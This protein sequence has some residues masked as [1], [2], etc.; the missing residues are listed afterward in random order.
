[1]TSN[2]AFTVDD[3]LS[4]HS[5]LSDKYLQDARQIALS[6]QCLCWSAQELVNQLVSVRGKLTLNRW[7]GHKWPFQ[8]INGRFL[9]PL[10]EHEA[11]QALIS[12]QL[13]SSL[14]AE[15]LAIQ[16]GSR[17]MR[18]L[19]WCRSHGYHVT[20]KS[21]FKFR[22]EWH[23]DYQFDSRLSVSSRLF[24]LGLSAQLVDQL[25]AV[26]AHQNPELR[27]LLELAEGKREYFSSTIELDGVPF[28]VKQ[29]SRGQLFSPD[30][31][32]ALLP[33]SE[34]GFTSLSAFAQSISAHI[35]RRFQEAVDAQKS[36]L[37]QLAEGRKASLIEA[38]HTYSKLDGFAQAVT[39]ALNCQA[40]SAHISIDLLLGDRTLTI[41]HSLDLPSDKL[42]SATE[43]EAMV[44]QAKAR[45]KQNFQRLQ[46]WSG[47]FDLQILE[48]PLLVKL[49]KQKPKQM[50]ASFL[51][52]RDKLHG[53]LAMNELVLNDPRFSRYHDLYPARHLEREWV[54]Y[55]G[56]TNSGKTHRSM[57]EMARVTHAVYLSPLRLMALE[58]QERLEDMGIPC[59]L[60]TGEE[61][62]IR[63]GATHFCCTVEEFARFK[64]QHWD[65]VIVDEVQ[66]L[67]DDQ[68]GWAWTDALVSA[69]TPRLIMT[70]PL[71]IQP[72]LE[73]LCHLC[74]DKLSVVE[75]QRLTPLGID[76]TPVKMEKIAAGS[77]IVAFSRK[78]VL[79]IKRILDMKGR[80]TAV[81]YGALSPVVRREQARRFRDGEAE[82]MIATDA[83]GMGLNLPAQAIYF[84]ADRKFDGTSVRTLSS[85]E[86]KQIGG[87]AG[88][89]GLSER[90]SIGAFTEEHLTTIRHRYNQKDREIELRKFAVRPN[91]EHLS[92]ISEVLNERSLL[93]VWLAFI[94]TV[95]YGEAFVAVLPAELMEWIRQ[96]DNPNIDLELRWIFACAPV[97]GGLEGYASQWLQEWL[98]CL[99]K[100]KAIVLPEYA[101]QM[102]LKGFEDALHMIDAYLH[103]ARAIPE[104][105]A[106]R[107]K[108]EALRELYNEKTLKALSQAKAQSGK[109]RFATA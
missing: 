27:L 39:H 7:N 90:G 6:S 64:H 84:Y 83:I 49:L 16:S 102:G 98:R 97:H 58:N 33:D 92:T 26:D 89:Y 76:A 44:V 10:S 109:T 96:I 62:I 108:A 78:T 69:Y 55:L 60:V 31:A 80:T 5:A 71:L 25:L 70:G 107:E 75:T 67:T 34:A 21:S 17:L 52:L 37:T 82:I 32:F 19:E 30:F 11:H 86:V 29:I 73:K 74:G 81:V 15:P 66:M 94:R 100:G 45:F 79:D 24:W 38:L 106:E 46:S 2:T 18:L 41:E 40:F 53:T 9:R 43:Y 61:E 35:G 88:R 51:P 63:P 56:P 1:M 12:G 65:V 105:F 72:S 22:S 23:H 3:L 36:K 54:A 99:H 4:G 101:P 91:F 42:L 95:N 48:T 47:K 68:R 57:E 85:Q 28:E 50:K 104:A 103:L 13:D 59:S 14:C 93:K 8:I 20:H 77:I 87:R